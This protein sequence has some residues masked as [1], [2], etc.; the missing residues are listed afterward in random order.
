MLSAGP[1]GDLK[2]ATAP[3][4]ATNA[5]RGGF[6]FQVSRPRLFTPAMPKR[7]LEPWMTSA[8]GPFVSIKPGGP[9]QGI[10]TI[11]A[12]TET[13]SPPLVVDATWKPLDGDRR[14]VSQP[15]DEYTAARRLA[16]EWAD[17]LAAGREPTS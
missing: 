3:G 15:V 11:S 9:L 10:V 12:N 6:S 4:R 14:S 2:A 8:S 17:Q 5:R 16:H 13:D 1:S 7:P